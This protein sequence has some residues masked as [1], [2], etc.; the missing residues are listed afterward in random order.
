MVELLPI[1]LNG[2]IIFLLWW[3]L[4]FIHELDIGLYESVGFIYCVFVDDFPAL[5]RSL[6]F[7][8]VEGYLIDKFDRLVSFDV[9]PSLLFG[10]IRH[11]LLLCLTS[12]YRIGHGLQTIQL[13]D[14]LLSAG[15][16]PQATFWL[17]AEILL[18]VIPFSGGGI[19]CEIGCVI[20]W[21]DFI[22]GNARKW[23]FA[24]LIVDQFMDDIL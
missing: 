5:I 21:F 4:A 24:E 11:F 6:C 22:G 15:M 8:L 17:A 13:L 1:L 18:L 2:F 20:G 10:I 3:V 7:L 14:N 9:Y 16:F 12:E 23:A 19:E